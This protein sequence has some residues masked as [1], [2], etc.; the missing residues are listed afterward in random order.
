[1]YTIVDNYSDYTNDIM[2]YYPILHNKSNSYF[3]ET[4]YT[5]LPTVLMEICHKSCV[6]SNDEELLNSDPLVVIERHHDELIYDGKVKN[7]FAPHSD[8]DGPANGPC[9]SI[10]Y[11]YAIDKEINN[12]GL[13]FY[14]WR[15]E[16]A[17]I[18]DDQIPV[19]TFIPT[20][21]DAITFGDNIPHCPGN[22]YTNSKSPQVRGVLAIFIK[23]PNKDTT[24]S[25]TCIP[26]LKC[27]KYF[28]R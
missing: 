4:R 16:S 21:G 13:H 5:K 14:K 17:D 9:R 26:L 20:T 18:I 24:T 6:K 11:Y 12:V 10:L 1:M 2:Q 7:H 23:Y 8:R 3:G 15:D 22:F 25:S 28:K 19:S 27:F